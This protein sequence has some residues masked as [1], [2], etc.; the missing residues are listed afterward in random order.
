MKRLDVRLRPGAEADIERLETWLALEGADIAVIDGYIDR[1]LERC[2]AIG[3][4][5]GVGRRR[6]D[7]RTGLRTVI[8]EKRILIA[9]RTHEDRVEIVNIFSHGRDYEAFYDEDDEWG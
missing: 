7:L 4:A 1:L 6:D 8:F 2:D 9:Y 5:P 3:D